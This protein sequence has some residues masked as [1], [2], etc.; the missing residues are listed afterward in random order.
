[1]SVGLP[2]GWARTTLEQVVENISYGFTASA[3]TASVGPR[4][5]RITDL[6]DSSVQWESVPYCKI[7]A[8]KIAKYSLRSGDIVFARTGATTG[9]SFLITSCPAAVFASY[10]IRVRLSTD[11]LPEFVAYFFQ[12]Q[13]YWN[14]VNENISGSAQPNCNASKLKTLNLPIVPLNEQRRI[15]AKLEKLLDKVDSCQK[16]LAKIPILL[17]R[18]RQSVLVAACSGKLT[19]DWRENQLSPESVES[20]IEKIRSLHGRDASNDL[21]NFQTQFAT[22]EDLPVIPDSWMWVSAVN[23]CSQITDGEHIQPP[24]QAT[25]RPMLSAKHVRD[26]FVTLEGAGL[27]SEKDFSKALQRCAPANG[28]ILIVSVGATTG[29]SAIVEDRPPFAI[30]RSVLLLKPLMCS[31]FLL[32]W[33]QTPWC[34]DWMTQASGASAQPHLYIKDTKRMPVP[35]P[36]PIEQ[37]EIVRRVDQLFSLADQIEARYERAREH[38]DNL[39][40]SILAKAFR[41]E[42]VQQDPNDE[43]ATVLLERIR[44]ARAI[45]PANRSRQRV[46]ESG[47][48]SKQLR[49][50]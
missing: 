33:L 46:N 23:V 31:R 10:L 45:Q 15:V 14:Q 24:Y 25:G 42:L 28:D 27:I 47:P 41:G 36:P 8:S 2:F 38:V 7:P 34:L 48:L 13:S 11:I 49:P 37:H 9:K 16:R 21:K 17:K 29:R 1:M 40:Q 5:L 43:P 20:T 50:P 18:F 32:R 44:E 35:F 3:S 6:Q 12:S 30:V 39:K 4:F 26:G 19:E 22:F